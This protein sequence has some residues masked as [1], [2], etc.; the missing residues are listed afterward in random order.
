M[1]STIILTSEQLVS[2]LPALV[3][4]ASFTYW[5]LSRV[6]S[7]SATPSVAISLQCVGDQSKDISYSKF[8]NPK[9]SPS[10]SSTIAKAAI[11]ILVMFSYPLQ[12][13][14]CRASVDSVLKWRP[15]KRFDP[16]N[17]SP[18]RHSLLMPSPKSRAQLK[19]DGMG[20]TRFAAITTAIIVLSYIVA[21]SVSSLEK[22]LAY[23]GS[24]GST[25]ISFILPGLFYYKITSP[26]SPHSPQHWRLTKEDDDEEDGSDLDD[27][28]GAL[29]GRGLEGSAWRRKMLRR[30]S[31]ALA[32]YGV[33]VMV[34]CL[35][36]NTIFVVAH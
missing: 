23:V 24:T 31:L 5:W 22:V 14:P 28:D 12:V 2:F 20:E 9:D 11:V 35:V 34:T 13:H 27:E 4:H 30:L 1:R 15:S 6:T 3:L 26:H 7:H 17:S 25:S 29:G 16:S 32:V 33:V 19:G 36:T 21:M 8:N 10:L 18:S